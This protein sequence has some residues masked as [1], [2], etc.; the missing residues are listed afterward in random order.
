MKKCPFCAEDIQE[1]AVKCKHCHEFLDESKRPISLHPPAL[2]YTPKV[3]L[4]WYFRTGFM[5]GTF[6]TM[7]P[8][9]LPSVWMHPK[10]HWV[11]KIVITAAVVGFCWLSYHAFK[12]LIQNL[13]DATK[14]I[15]EMKI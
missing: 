1:E 2:P 13:E 3:A 9:V 6:V 12:A 14:M 11:W 8:F 4:P 10:M 5:I 7:P 15:N